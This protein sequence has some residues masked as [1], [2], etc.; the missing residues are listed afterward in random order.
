M[1]ALSTAMYLLFLCDLICG[2]YTAVRPLL[3][4]VQVRESPT[5]KTVHRL[6]HAGQV[7]L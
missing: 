6:L 2:I 3:F 5:N 1:I 7:K 4:P